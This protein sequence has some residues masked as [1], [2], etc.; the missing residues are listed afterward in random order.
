MGIALFALIPV[1]QWRRA[2]WLVSTLIAL[3]ICIQVASV[4]YSFGLEFFQ[5]GR[6]GTI[7][8]NYVWR[9]DESQLL[10]R[11]QNIALHIAGIPNYNCIP[12]EKQIPDIWKITFSR[13][14]VKQIHTIA[15]FPF[16]ARSYLGNN[17]LFIVLLVLWLGCLMMLCTTITLWIKKLKSS[18]LTG[19]T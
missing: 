12:P 19:K 6:H 18:K 13:E 2:K 10:C 3:S 7:P 17:N 16:K 4:T 15:A 8:D 1:L 11:F 5:D 9:I 14:Q